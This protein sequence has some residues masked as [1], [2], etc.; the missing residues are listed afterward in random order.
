MEGQKNECEQFCTKCANCAPGAW[1]GASAYAVRYVAPDFGVCW[2]EA[3]TEPLAL[4]AGE[5]IRQ[6]L[7]GEGEHPAGGV[8]VYLRVFSFP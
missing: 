6:A 7:C 3:P 4:A 2:H 1:A 5:D 8:H